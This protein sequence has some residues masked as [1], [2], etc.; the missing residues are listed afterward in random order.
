LKKIDYELNHE[1]AF[2]SI[3]IVRDYRPSLQPVPCIALEIQQVILNLFKNAAQAFKKSK[4]TH[5][6]P[7]ITIRTSEMEEMVCI[8]IEDNGPGIEDEILPSVHP[9]IPS[10]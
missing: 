9:F 10:Y 3:H 5:E 2:K 6:R 8:A 4:M 7:I 1:L